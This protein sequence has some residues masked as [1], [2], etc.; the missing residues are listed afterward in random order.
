M[1]TLR[2]NV[3][4]PKV[5]RLEYPEGE[6]TFRGS[7]HLDNDPIVRDSI[8]DLLFA[9]FGNHPGNEQDM[10]FSDY[11]FTTGNPVI[12]RIHQHWAIVHARSMSVGDVVHFDDSDTYY[13]CDSSGWLPVNEVTAKSWLNFPREYGCCSFELKKFKK[14][15]LAAL[16]S[17]AFLIVFRSNE[18]LQEQDG[19]EERNLQDRHPADQGHLQ[20]RR[21]AERQPDLEKP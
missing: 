13:I 14:L 1:I 9:G 11:K 4:Y 10:G 18:T 3:T 21:L 5:D 6:R 16:P 20:G 15:Y 17:T 8:C 2:Y 7:I 12:D 19:D